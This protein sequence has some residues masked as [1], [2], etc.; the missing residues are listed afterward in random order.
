VQLQ[1]RDVQPLPRS[2]KAK[3]TQALKNKVIKL[4]AEADEQQGQVADFQKQVFI[5]QPE[6]TVSN[7]E[8]AKK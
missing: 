2:K 5:L 6:N 8:V 4:E 1:Q 3:E 7:G